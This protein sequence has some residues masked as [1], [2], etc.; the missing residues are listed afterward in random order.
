MKLID[1]DIHGSQNYFEEESITQ[2]LLVTRRQR[3]WAAWKV[4][5]GEAGIILLKIKPKDFYVNA[6]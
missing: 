6:K 3:L 4:L 5:K 2:C 1:I